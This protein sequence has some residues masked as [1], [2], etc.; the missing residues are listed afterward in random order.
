MQ[1]PDSGGQI[2]SF[3]RGRVLTYPT[4]TPAILGGSGAQLAGGAA[5]LKRQK[6]PKP[7]IANMLSFRVI[8]SDPELDLNLEELMCEQETVKTEDTFHLRTVSL[9]F[10]LLLELQP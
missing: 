4:P 8:Y 9:R 6:S 7:L 5:S 3:S 10:L 1:T 2:G